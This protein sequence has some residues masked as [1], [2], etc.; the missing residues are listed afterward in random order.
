MVGTQGAGGLFE[1]GLVSGLSLRQPSGPEEEG[2]VGR[3]RHDHVGMVGAQE[4]LLELHR[5]PVQGVGPDRVSQLEG[6][7]GH[8][9]Q[10]EGGVGVGL[11]VDPA[12]HVQGF[13][14]HA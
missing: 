12:V 11:G 2:R 7:V 4:G 3:P 5:G 14:A 6:G 13:P 9:G 1:D 8:R 10:G